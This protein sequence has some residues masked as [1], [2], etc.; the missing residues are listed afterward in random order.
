MG[1]LSYNMTKPV[2]VWFKENYEYPESDYEVLD[3]ALVK[4][5][6]LY[7]AVKQKS[8]GD[9]FCAVYLVRWTRDYNNFSYKPMTEHCGPGMRECPEKIFKLLTP[10]NDINDPNGWGREWRKYVE[11]LHNIRKSLKGNFIIEVEKP[12]SF[13]NGLEYSYFK[14]LGKSFYA[15]Q[16]NKDNVTN[17]IT[18]I[19]GIKIRNRFR[20]HL[21][22]TNF[23][24]IK[25]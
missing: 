12:I 1:W 24:L 5:N 4:R 23:K 19:N 25:L 16:I 8:T 13:S 10:L 11:N 17:G 6:T 22:N 14:K 20:N 9:V 21:I 7:A 3:S 15:G 18:F 2:K